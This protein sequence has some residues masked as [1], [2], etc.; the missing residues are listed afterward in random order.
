[1]KNINFTKPKKFSLIE[2]WKQPKPIIY[3]P[4]TIILNDR[5]KGKNEQKTNI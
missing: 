3:L 5:G 1:M 2:F 4:I